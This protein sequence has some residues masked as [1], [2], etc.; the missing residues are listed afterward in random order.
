MYVCVCVRERER[1]CVCVWG[2]GVNK[3]VCVCTQ[4]RRGLYRYHYLVPVTSQWSDIFPVH[5]THE[6]N[7][8]ML[9]SRWYNHAVQSGNHEKAN[10]K[11]DQPTS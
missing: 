5:V 9:V 4:A 11:I 3:C 2:G 1:E 6:F 8:R 7:R 10:E